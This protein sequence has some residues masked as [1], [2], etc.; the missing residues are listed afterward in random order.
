MPQH[1]GH[2]AN[3]RTDTITVSR[4]EFARRVVARA[5]PDEPAA[6]PLL[7]RPRARTSTLRDTP[8]QRADGVVGEVALLRPGGDQEPAS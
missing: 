2:T 7:S 3:S 8:L 5:A 6:F 1:S 4:E